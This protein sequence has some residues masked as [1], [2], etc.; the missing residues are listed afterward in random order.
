MYRTLF[1]LAGP[2]IGAWALLIFLPGWSFT[3][4]LAESALVPVYLAVL[5]VVG[6]SAVFRELGPGIMRDFGSAGGVLALLRS[7]PVALVAWIHI[8]VFDQVVAHLIYRDNMKHRW[9]PLPVQS[10]LLVFTLMLGP[11]GFVTYWA[12]RVGRSR[13]IV[14]WGEADPIAPAQ[15]GAA[16]VPV[17]F[18]SIVP[19]DSLGAAVLGLWRRE[20]PLVAL[21]AAG[22]LLAGVCAVVAMV[23]GGW[24]IFPEGRLLEAAKFDVALGIYFLT[25]A[26]ILPLAGMQAWQRRRWVRWTI[27]LATCAFSMENVQAWRGLDPRFSRVGGPLDQALGGLFFLTALGVATTFVILLAR[28]F[29]RDALPDHPALVIGLR[30]ATAT[31][32]LAFGVGVV[33][34]AAQGRFLNGMGNLMPIHAAGFHGLQAVPLVA[35]RFG[36]GRGS[37]ETSIRW[38]HVAGVGWVIFC[39]GLAV[40]ALTELPPLAVSVPL[41][42]SAGGGLVWTAALGSAWRAHAWESVDVAGRISC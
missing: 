13:R 41:A 22:L 24:L 33:M 25:L 6:V 38:T 26:L 39:A 5:Y 28:F 23:N 36:W 7:E 40:Q 32:L 3:R 8:L 31:A 30:Y 18:Q 14:A 15:K 21:G 29:R 19:E 11:V 42:L 4:R 35:L 1:D 17:R 12:I 27:G 16:P 20:R 2:A 10:L 9:V 34:S 37:I